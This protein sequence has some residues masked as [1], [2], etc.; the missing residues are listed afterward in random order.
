MLKKIL[1]VAVM[2]GVVACSPFER[3]TTVDD[4]VNLSGRCIRLRQSLYILR[5]A[6]GQGR[7]YLSQSE[8]TVDTT[9][10]KIDK[11]ME[12]AVRAVRLESSFEI[13]TLAILGSTRS[14]DEPFNVS[15]IFSPP[16]IVAA[17]QA[18]KWGETSAP[19]LRAP[20]LN[21]EIAEWCLNENAG[22]DS[23][24]RVNISH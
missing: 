7:A 20:E 14:S 10:G 1:L 22:V 8:S 18:L 6:S 24:T 19:I 16:W 4:H 5:P 21:S 9:V 2:F 3:T 13:T 23:E 17:S 12:F 11:G 15:P